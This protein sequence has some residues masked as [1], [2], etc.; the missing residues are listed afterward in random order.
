MAP[1]ATQPVVSTAMVYHT[2]A[3]VRRVTAHLQGSV[4]ADAD[5]LLRMMEMYD[6]EGQAVVTVRFE[7]GNPITVKMKLQRPVTVHEPEKL[8]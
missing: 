5:V 1:G 3:E 6:P 7:T 2:L 4:R 8:H